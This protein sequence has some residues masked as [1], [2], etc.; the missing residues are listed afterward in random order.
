MDPK[1]QQTAFVYT[2]YIQETPERV[3]QGLTDPALMNDSGVIVGGAFVYSGGT[4]Q[5]LNNLIPAGFGYQIQNATGIT[6]ARSS[7]TPT[8]P[9]PA[10]PTPCC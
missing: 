9:P 2:T 10:R 1:G 3:W 6:T 4:L 7:P 5:N 8:T